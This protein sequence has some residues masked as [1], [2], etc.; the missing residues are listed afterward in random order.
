MN[1]TEQEN[2]IVDELSAVMKKHRSL[3]ALYLIECFRIAYEKEIG[4]ALHGTRPKPST[5]TRKRSGRKTSC[6]TD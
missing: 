5:K 3:G 4:Y 6:P 2:Q 1:L